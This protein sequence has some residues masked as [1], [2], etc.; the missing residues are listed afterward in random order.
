MFVRLQIDRNFA[1]KFLNEKHI[2][3]KKVLPS[4]AV[5][6]LLWRHSVRYY[7]LYFSYVQTDRV[8]N[9]IY[10]YNQ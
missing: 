8:F 9:A 1:G 7:S 4:F 6:T 2:D 3:Y 10:Q 5:F